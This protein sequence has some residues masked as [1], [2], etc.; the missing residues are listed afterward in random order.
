MT[1]TFSN[2]YTCNERYD[3]P[4]YREE[5]QQAQKLDVHSQISAL[6]IERDNL[7]TKIESKCR[8]LKA[9]E[10]TIRWEHL[11]LLVKHYVD[12]VVDMVLKVK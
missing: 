7:N 12:K 8:T 10:K 6:E 1:T 2:A 9:I 11:R 4:L 5:V 3:K